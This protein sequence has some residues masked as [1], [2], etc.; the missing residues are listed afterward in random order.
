MC[1]KTLSLFLRSETSPLHCTDLVDALVGAA[2]RDDHEEREVG[3]PAEDEGAHDDA[4]LRGRLL[5]LGQHQVGVGALV[6]RVRLLRAR[7]Q[8]AAALA[9]LAATQE[10]QEA[11][12]RLGALQ[13][14]RRR[15]R[16]R[17]GGCG[18]LGRRP[19][20]AGAGGQRHGLLA[21]AVTILRGGK[22]QKELVI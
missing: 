6:L 14:R 1:W 17:R 5:L 9:A 12:A 19:V 15:R 3:Q 11:L 16:R 2:V 22:F 8:A 20:V 7:E 21:T 10:R 18:G 13:E 4:E